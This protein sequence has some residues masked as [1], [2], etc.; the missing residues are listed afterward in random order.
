MHCQGRHMDLA[1]WH[2][3]QS[4]SICTCIRL[5][6]KEPRTWVERWLPLNMNPRRQPANTAKTE[7]V[8]KPLSFRYS[9]SHCFKS[10]T[11][12]PC[13]NVLT[14]SYMGFPPES[15]LGEYELL[16]YRVSFPSVGSSSSSI[17]P[18]PSLGR[19]STSSG[20]GN[21]FSLHGD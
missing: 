3:K 18:S 6:D 8:S 15:P 20:G 11:K 21:S 13:K 4:S 7:S 9:L 2:F 5:C 19:Q 10:T 17:V 1:G 14:R 12:V 16:L